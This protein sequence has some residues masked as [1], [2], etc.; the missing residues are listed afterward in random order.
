M[1]RG[2]LEHFRIGLA[3]PRTDH[4]R[5]EG[6]FVIALAGLASRFSAIALPWWAKWLA[7]GVLL[8]AVYGVGRVHEARRGQEFHSDYVA[9]QAQ[10]TIAI[11]KRQVQVVIKT[12]IKYRERIK[13][14][15]VQGAIIENDIPKYI[16]PADTERFRVNTGF[17]RVLDAAWT[18]DTIGPA[19]DSDREPAS[20]PLDDIGAIQA[21]N[22]TSCRAWR[23]QAYG[24]RDFYARQQIAIN[25]KAGEWARTA[26]AGEE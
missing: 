21:S 1:E 13:K 2:S 18:G 7:L 12:E 6:S 25:G 16:T 20:V 3:E 9:K 17:V 11:A 19:T 24:W 23:E 5:A 10:Q 15:Y 14:I 26:P 8:A 4:A 22:A